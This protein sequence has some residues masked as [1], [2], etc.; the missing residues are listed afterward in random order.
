MNFF[1]V[2]LHTPMSHT[3]TNKRMI[4]FHGVKGRKSKVE[5]KKDGGLSI[6]NS[7]GLVNDLPLSAMIFVAIADE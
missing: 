7:H 3:L 2:K 4:I 5:G 1:Y 6:H